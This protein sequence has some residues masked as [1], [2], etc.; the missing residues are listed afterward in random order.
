MLFVFRILK[1]LKLD[2]PWM[3]CHVK[4]NFNNVY[5]FCQWSFGRDRRLD[6]EADTK[7]LRA[8][9]L[10]KICQNSG[11]LP[12]EWKIGQNS[13]K[14]A[15]IVEK[16]PNMNAMIQNARSRRVDTDKA[17]A[18]VKISISDNLLKSYNISL[19]KTFI[20]H[21]FCCLISIFVNL[22][23]LE[24]NVLFIKSDTGFSYHQYKSLILSSRCKNIST[25]VKYEYVL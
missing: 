11:Q 22:I 5:F 24:C 21:Y 16:L 8:K 19:S 7:L 10:V 6:F 25:L 12:W 20:V 9:I 1:V 3:K 15:K 17:D 23:F 14:S 18:Q 13:G 2:D 4:H